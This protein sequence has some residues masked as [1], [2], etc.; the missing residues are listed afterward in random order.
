MAELMVWAEQTPGL[1]KFPA[2]DPHR[3][4]LEHWIWSN[5]KALGTAILDVGV[6]IPRRYLGDGYITLGENG[7]DTK[8]DLLALPFPDNVFDGFVLTEVLEH[9]TDPMRAM[10]EVF[11]VLK[12]GGLL[13]VTSPF[14]WPEHGI[15]GEYKDYWRFTRHG[16]ELLLQPFTIIDIVPCEWTPEGAAAYDQMRRF[17]CMGF[18]NQT[19]MTTG[20]L[21][22]AVKPDPNRV[23]KPKGRGMPIGF[24]EDV[25]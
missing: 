8:G 25:P 3:L 22:R 2:P 6:Y 10:R 15:E 12:P 24:T 11:R 20:Y 14:C 23:V 5:R 1:H 19:R 18:D 4:Q 17:E 7:E 21:C 16:W 13:L 9:C